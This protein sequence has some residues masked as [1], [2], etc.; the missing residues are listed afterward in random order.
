MS[1]RIKILA[2]L[3][4]LALITLIIIL[5]TQSKVATVTVVPVAQPTV[6]PNT[7]KSVSRKDLMLRLADDD[8]YYGPEEAPIIMVEFSDYLCPWCGKFYFE[9]L[10]QILAAYPDQV[11]YVHRDYP[12]LGMDDKDAPLRAAVAAGCAL[13]QG[14]FWEMHTELFEPY[15]NM[16]IEPHDAS[17]PPDPAKREAMSLPYQAAALR[18]SAGKAGLNLT[19]YDACVA[20]Q[21]PAQEVQHDLEDGMQLNINSVPT[22]VINGILVEGSQTFAVFAQIIDKALVEAPLR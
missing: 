4:G 22:Y 9:T 12:V 14:R 17:S 10:P 7:T 11:R 3:G 16:E 18:E 19:V 5:A 2:G 8:P 1:H 20:A 13:A 6:T 15:R 21:T